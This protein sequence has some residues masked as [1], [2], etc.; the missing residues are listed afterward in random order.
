[1]C[2]ALFISRRPGCMVLMDLP[3][4]EGSA[5][6]HCRWKCWSW[7]ALHS[8]AACAVLIK[9]TNS[10]SQIS[11]WP[12]AVFSKLVG[13]KKAPYFFFFFVDLLWC[14][15]HSSRKWEF[16]SSVSG[17]GVVRVDRRQIVKRPGTQC[18]LLCLRR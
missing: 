18:I 4:F 16:A 13:G 10:S 14:V 7:Q 9:E 17:R 6:R 1:M 12:S 8:G 11:P 15:S 5:S 2:S 3:N